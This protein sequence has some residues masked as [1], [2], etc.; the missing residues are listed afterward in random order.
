MLP[1]HV[2]QTV[3]NHD[4]RTSGAF[5]GPIP[6]PSLLASYDE[7][8]PGLAERLVKMAETQATHR[9]GIESRLVDARISTEKAGMFCGVFVAIAVLAAASWFAYL[10]HPVSAAFLGIGDL[11]ALVTVFVTGQ[12]AK[13]A[14]KAEVATKKALPE[15]S[16]KA[17]PEKTEKAEKTEE[18]DASPPSEPAAPS[19]PDP[20]A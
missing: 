7:V 4:T 10:G 20:E 9:Q 2:A 19:E 5:M 11:T 18:T 15:K 16:E 13:A 3:A 14:K 17:L 12:R 1:D 6:P 8:Q